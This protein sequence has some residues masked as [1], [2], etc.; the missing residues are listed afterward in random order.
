MLVRLSALAVGLTL[1]LSVAAAHAYESPVA[2]TAVAKN[3]ADALAEL[4]LEEPT[5][6]PATRCS[7]RPK[8]GMTALVN[9]LGRHADGVFW[10]TYRCEKW[11]K[12]SASLH[13]EGRAVDW[14]LDVAVPAQRKEAERLIALL[15]APDKLGQPQALARRMGVEEIIWDCG[16]WGAGMDRFRPYSPCLSKKGKLK[17]KVNKTIAHRDHLHIGMTK[18]GAAKKTSFWTRRASS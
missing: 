8:P 2:Y 16:Y 11:G 5:Y 3:P 6:D 4:P 14:A 15:L 7:K 1:S 10:G 9:W 13:A 18:R 17:R 12:G